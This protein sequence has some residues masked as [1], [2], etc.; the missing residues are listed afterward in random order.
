MSYDDVIFGVTLESITE[1]LYLGLIRTEIPRDYGVLVNPETTT[2]IIRKTVI[3]NNFD[4]PVEKIRALQKN[5]CKIVSRIYYGEDIDFSPYLVRYNPK[6]IWN[7]E[8]GFSWSFDS[9]V[10]HM[11][12][13]T[14]DMIRRGKKGETDYLGFLGHQVGLRVYPGPYQ[15]LDLVKI[16]KGRW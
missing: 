6:I 15:D 2:Y 10:L 13:P 7:G 8:S 11:S 3:I 16:K 1:A 14:P 4:Y 5:E 9:G 12:K